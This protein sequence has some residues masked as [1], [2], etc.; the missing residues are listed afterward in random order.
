MFKNADKRKCFDPEE[1]DSIH[2]KI[3]PD[4]NGFYIILHDPKAKHLMYTGWV[5]SKKKL[6]EKI[7]DLMSIAEKDHI[8][9][10]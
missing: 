10:P 4:E 7:S 6:T 9:I 5:T 3:A 8:D 1:N 2:I